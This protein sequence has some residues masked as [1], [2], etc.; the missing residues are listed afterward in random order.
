MIAVWNVTDHGDVPPRAA[1]KGP[2]SGLIHAGGLAVDVK[3]REI[4]AADSVRNG[5]F[6]FLVPEFF[7]AN[8]Q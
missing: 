3:N 8:L 2:I 4:F 1:I 6:T 5:V 7:G